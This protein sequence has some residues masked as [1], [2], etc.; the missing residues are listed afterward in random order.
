VPKNSEIVFLGCCSRWSLNPRL[1]SGT[2]PAFRTFAARHITLLDVR[3]PAKAESPRPCCKI[4]LTH[5]LTDETL[6]SVIEG[7]DFLETL[8]AFQKLAGG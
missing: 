2:P 7:R 8:E 6:R 3:G 5:K 4:Y 1:L